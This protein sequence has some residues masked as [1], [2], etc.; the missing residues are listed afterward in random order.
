MSLLLVCLFTA[1]FSTDDEKQSYRR[2]NKMFRVY[3]NYKSKID[4]EVDVDGE[5]WTSFRK[6][7]MFSNQI[8]N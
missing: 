4:A 1:N 2:N 3:K 7:T 6:L 5:G 8:S